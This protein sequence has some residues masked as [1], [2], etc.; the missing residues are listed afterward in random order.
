M[1]NDNSTDRY[2]TY[3][4]VSIC[5]ALVFMVAITCGTPAKICMWTVKASDI[6]K[7]AAYIE[8]ETR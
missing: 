8:E 3:G 4:V 2:V 7:C 6:D 5:I 1:R